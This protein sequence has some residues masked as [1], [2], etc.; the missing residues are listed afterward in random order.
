MTGLSKQNGQPV[1]HSLSLALLLSLALHGSALAALVWWR[2]PQ[3]AIPETVIAVEWVGGSAA[4]GAQAAA[5]VPVSSAKPSSQTAGTKSPGAPLPQSRLAVSF[6][7]TAQTAALERDPLPPAPDKAL[8]APQEIRQIREAPAAA[9]PPP[10][11]PRRKPHPTEITEAPAQAGDAPETPGRA[12]GQQLAH[13]ARGPTGEAGSGGSNSGAAA[14]AT[15]ALFE[16]P[17]L[18]NP[19]PRYPR[20][21]RLRGLEGKLVVRA[22]VSPQGQARTVW[23]ERSSGHKILDAAALEAIKGWRFIPATLAGLP[24]ESLVDVPVNYYLQ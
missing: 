16:G 18:A 10:P 13:A 24:V 6:Q 22:E 17:G 21:A 12:R 20:A 23:V 1:G 11:L 9:V 5:G 8:A 2:A 3:V 7:T 4:A 19:V 14:G 15:A